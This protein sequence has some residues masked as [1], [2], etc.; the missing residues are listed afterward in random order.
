MNSDN[1][2]SKK[3]IFKAIASGVFGFF[4]IFYITY[5]IDGFDF[6]ALIEAINRKRYFIVIHP[7]LLAFWSFNFIGLLFLGLT[8]LL[9]FEFYS[10]KNEVFIGEVRSPKIKKLALYFLVFTLAGTVFFTLFIPFSFI[11]P[12][13]I[14]ANSLGYPIHCSDEPYALYK[15]LRKK[16]TGRVIWSDRYAKTP[17]DCPKYYFISN[18]PERQKETIQDQDLFYQERNE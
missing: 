11:F 8:F 4:A 6:L 1:K 5:Y 15:S 3:V 7:V 12:S 14:I 10:Y 17:W 16:R 13:G 9:I 2:K 18:D